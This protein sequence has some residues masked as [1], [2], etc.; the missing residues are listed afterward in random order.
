MFLGVDGGGTKT[1]FALIS[2][3]GRVLARGEGGSSYHAE[4]GLAGVR[5]VLK[6][7]VQE[8]CATAGVTVSA[9]R[10]AWFGLPAYGEDPAVDAELALAP[11]AA[12]SPSQYSCGNDMVCGWAGALAGSDGICVTAGTGSI[13]YGEWRGRSARS[14]GWGETFGDE[15]SAHW[16]GR[17]GLAAF[18]RMGDGRAAPGPLQAH[19]RRHYGLARDLDLAGR[20]A[21]GGAAERSA[22]AALARVVAAAAAEGDPAARAIFATAGRELAALASATRSLLGVPDT[23]TVPL[24]YAG[25]VWQSGPLVLE[26]FRGALA[27]GP[28]YHF[29]SPLL[30]PVYG[31]ALCAARAAGVRFSAAAIAALAASEPHPAGAP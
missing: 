6:R 10:Q 13:A 14:G 23:E 8:L 16:I 22:I 18:S 28:P 7:G 3:D 2:A 4:V 21:A 24:S 17:E 25:G 12:L 5:E 31:A 11:R 20:I 26:S 27:G 9:I 15:G 30:R 29:Q 1:A 19:V